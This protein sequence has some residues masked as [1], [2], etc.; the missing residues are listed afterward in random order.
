MANSALKKFTGYDAWQSSP[1]TCGPLGWNDAATPFSLVDGDTP[2]A[3]GVSDH[4]VPYVPSVLTNRGVVQWILERGKDL[5]KQCEGNLGNPYWPGAASGITIGYGYDMKERTRDEVRRHLTDS[6]VP[7]DLAKLLS[8]GAGVSRFTKPDA[9][10][11]LQS[12]VDF[13]GA[14][15]HFRYLQIDQPARDHLFEIVYRVYVED[16][17]RICAKPDAVAAYGKPDWQALHPAIK[18]VLVDLR[19]RGDYSRESRQYIQ[20]SVVKNDPV[21]FADQLQRFLDDH[22]DVYDSGITSR[23]ERRIKFAR[24]YGAI[25]VK[26]GGC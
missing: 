12:T 11:F 16:V 5:T 20:K 26:L 4:A 14:K 21:A 13:R 25:P 6:G 23:F 8:T 15:V 17:A 18:A 9:P 3:L 19:F 22:D 24:Q 7:D 10:A 1:R 2:G